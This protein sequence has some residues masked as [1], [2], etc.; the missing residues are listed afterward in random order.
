MLRSGAIFGQKID[1]GA[2]DELMRFDAERCHDLLRFEPA[3]ARGLV[4][5]QH[6]FQLKEMAQPLNVVEMHSGATDEKQSAVFDHAA[7]LSVGQRQR[8]AKRLGRRRERA[9]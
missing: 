5:D 3:A 1:V 6:D 2:F 8:L 4:I 7:R 9:T